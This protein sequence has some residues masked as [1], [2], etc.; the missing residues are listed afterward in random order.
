MHGQQNIKKRLFLIVVSLVSGYAVN[1]TTIVF[2]RCY[3][4]G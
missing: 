3:T 1:N 2:I 4:L